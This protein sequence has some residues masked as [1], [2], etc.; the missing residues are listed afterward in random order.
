[1]YYSLL[2]SKIYQFFSKGK[3]S[4]TYTL[5]LLNMILVVAGFFLRNVLLVFVNFKYVINLK[6]NNLNM[7]LLCYLQTFLAYIIVYTLFVSVS[8]K[9]RS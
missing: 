8:C 4:Q 3:N 1:M 5:G 7:L 6:K 9:A 2:V